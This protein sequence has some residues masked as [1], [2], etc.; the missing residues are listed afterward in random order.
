MKVVRN[1]NKKEF[2]PIELTITIESLSELNTLLA[3]LHLSSERVN[4]QQTCSFKATKGDE[5]ALFRTLNEI[6]N[7]IK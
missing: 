1:D 3:R 2:E 5:N 7:K 4:V 6:H